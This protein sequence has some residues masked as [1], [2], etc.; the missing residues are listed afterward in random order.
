MKL[1]KASWFV[2]NME[3]RNFNELKLT[4]RIISMH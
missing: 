1:R 4:Q 2:M 3:K